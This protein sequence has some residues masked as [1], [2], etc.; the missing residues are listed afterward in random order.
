MSDQSFAKIAD[1]EYERRHAKAL[2]GLRVK[3]IRMSDRRLLTYTRKVLTTT[4]AA[5]YTVLAQ[6]SGLASTTLN[7]IARGLQRRLHDDTRERLVG[8]VAELEHQ[9]ALAEP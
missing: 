6:H 7:D 1:A 9:H 3:L 8:F 5:S 2:A 4:T